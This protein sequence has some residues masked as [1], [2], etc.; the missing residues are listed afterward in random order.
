MANNAPKQ[1]SN[2]CKNCG[3]SVIPAAA[4]GTAA[5]ADNTAITFCCR[6]GRQVAADGTCGNNVCPFFGEVPNCGG[7]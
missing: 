5:A 7:T 2:F 1:P 4:A 6:C 3:Q